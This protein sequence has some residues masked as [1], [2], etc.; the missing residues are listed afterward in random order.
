VYGAFVGVAMGLVLGWVVIVALRDQGLDKYSV[1]V[2]TIGWIMVL[3]FVA[4]VAAA[5]VPAWRATRLDVLRAIAA[6]G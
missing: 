3:A 6:D 1:P 2:A 5:V 4:G